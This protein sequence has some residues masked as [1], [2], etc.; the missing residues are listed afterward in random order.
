MTSFIAPSKVHQSC[1]S[2]TSNQTPTIHTLLCQTEKGLQLCYA[3][4]AVGTEEDKAKAWFVVSQ[5]V[6]FVVPSSSPST[7][8]HVI[9]LETSC[10]CFCSECLD[11]DT[12][13]CKVCRLMNLAQFYFNIDYVS[14]IHRSMLG[15]V[16][17]RAKEEC[18][19][20]DIEF[21]IVDIIVLPTTMNVALLWVGLYIRRLVPKALLSCLLSCRN[22]LARN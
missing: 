9:H 14:S 5:C 17:D 10:L 19:M 6:H 1:H 12:R 15:L 7:K 22:T 16:N 20:E 2:C 3:V 13:F 11:S 4:Y 18:R 8:G 21:R